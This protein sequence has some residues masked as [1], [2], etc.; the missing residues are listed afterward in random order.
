MKI[1]FGVLNPSEISDVV[2]VQNPAYGNNIAGYGSRPV[3]PPVCWIKKLEHRN[4][5]YTK[6]EQSIL[7][8]G[9]RN[10]IFCNAIEEGTFSRVGTSRL[11]LAKKHKLDVPCIIADYVGAWDHLEELKNEEE[12]RAK[13]QDQ[14]H[15]IDLE[16]PTKVGHVWIGGLPHHHLNETE[17]EYEERFDR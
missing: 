7:E 16:S 6:L 10:P 13:F 17:Q 12:I 8:E 2:L 11:W 3:K 1:R 9:F 15:L 14:P 5:F 4:Q